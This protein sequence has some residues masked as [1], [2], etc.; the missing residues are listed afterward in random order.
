MYV[1]TTFK[2]NK[3]VGLKPY[4]TVLICMKVLVKVDRDKQNRSN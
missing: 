1:N 3:I 4:N 2:I